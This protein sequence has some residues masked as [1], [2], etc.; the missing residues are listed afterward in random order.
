[1]C[2]IAGLYD[3]H[4]RADL[5]RVQAM[6]QLL[7]HRGPDDEG[8]VLIDPVGGQWSTHGGADTPPAVFRSGLPWAPA[9][10]HGAPATA[11]HGVALAH[12]RLAI[13]DLEPTGHQ[14]LCDAAQEMWITYNGEIYNHVELRQELERAGHR[15]RGTSDTE[16]IVAAYR[17]WGEDCLSHLNG[18][19]GFALWDAGRR[20]LFCARDRLGVKPFYYQYDG[21]VFA[22]ASEARALVLTQAWRIQPHL[23]AVRDLLAL[24]WVDHESHTFF[25][26]LR[27]LPAGH[28]LAVG[29]DGFRVER[30]WTLPDDGPAS[31]TAAD[32]AHEFADL[33]T[34]A[35]KL[36]L[37]ADVE[38]GACLSGGLDSSA[39]LTTAARLRN[40]GLHA[41]TC[42]YEEGPAYDERAYVRAV[43][44]TTGAQSHVVVPDGSDFWSVFDALADHQGEPTAGQGVYSQWQVMKLARQHGL[45]VLLDGQ[46]GDETLA[47]YFRYLPTRLRD[48]AAT[49]QWGRFAALFG[50]VSDRLGLA[51]TL[52]HTFEPWLPAALVGALR[53]R[54]G[55]GKD[56]VLASRL[57]KV[58]SQAPRA[59]RGT[60]SALWDQLAYDTLVRQLPS[61]L[62]YEDRSS[63]AFGIE[64]RLPFLDYRLVEFAFSLPDGERLDGTTT[65]AIARAALGD[66]VPRLVLERRDKMGFETPTDLWFRGRHAGE[67]RRRLTRSG[68]FQEWVDPQVVGDA[69][70]DFLAGRREI[71]LQVWRWLSL[72]AWSRHYLARDPRVVGRPPDPA[73]SAG[74]HLG[75]VEAVAHHESD[76]AA[77][78]TAG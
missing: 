19:F 54:F 37:R 14:P 60:R 75:Y 49:G 45:K 38:V 67:V 72:E 5:G 71:G 25:E 44:E 59:A 40:A 58:P 62:R 78:T 63:M 57:R 35:V 61:L 50:P 65:K 3:R 70:E 29:E 32:H 41:F 16:V 17:Q 7:R 51:T 33:F 55:Q 15:F 27:Q 68:P 64:T 46:G 31:G 39:V 28:W 18:M 30:W 42:A 21:H 36:R 13:V 73:V 11:R 34:D 77:G 52:L 47:G 56:L 10:T 6:S 2:G 22:F 26:G 76:L 24:D 23:P 74:R 69:L 1:M 66:R 12:R 4:G 9:G 43:A 53:R 48:L 20:R 8:L